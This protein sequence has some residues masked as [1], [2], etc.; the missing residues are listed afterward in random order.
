M[1]EGLENLDEK[2]LEAEVAKA[3]ETEET[4]EE[5]TPSKTSEKTEEKEE[6]A[7][8]EP[9]RTETS[10]KTEK[11]EPAAEETEEDTRFDKHPRWQKMKQERDDAVAEA[12]SLRDIREK[13]GDFQVDELTRLKDAAK[14]LRDNPTLADKVREM[15]DKFPFENEAINNKFNQVIAEQTRINNQLVLEKYDTTVSRLM[16]DNKVD[17]DVEP[18]V[19]ELLDNRVIKNSLTLDKVPD[20]VAKIL[21]AVETIRRKTLASYVEVKKGEPK[22]PV[23]S[24]Q[25]GKVILTK[26]E[27]EEAGDVVDELTEGLRAARPEIKSE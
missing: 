2:T 12:S 20:E 3:S 27:S 1:P 4:E 17:K 8:E 5:S 16:T 14:L 11:E 19:K 7:E 10:L 26:K 15:I 22:I 6:T 18:I 9:S 24:T 13:I 23:S 25:R 21:K